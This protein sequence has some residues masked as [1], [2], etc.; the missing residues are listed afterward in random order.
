M[1]GYRALLLIACGLYGLAL[2]FATRVRLL[3]DRELE[4]IA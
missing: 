1:T 3:G 4:V 2:L